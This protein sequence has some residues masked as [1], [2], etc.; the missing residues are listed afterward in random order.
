MSC[1]KERRK[2]IVAGILAGILARFLARILAKILAQILARSLGILHPDSLKSNFYCPGIFPFL[3]H[4]EFFLL[5]IYSIGGESNVNCS[6]ILILTR[7]VICCSRW[8]FRCWPN[9]FLSYTSHINRLLPKKIPPVMVH[10][11][12]DSEMKRTRFDFK[13]LDGV[14]KYSATVK[15]RRCLCT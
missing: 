6:L 5:R 10:Y 8:V 11:F 3:L 9:F 13:N 14:A 15:T 7:Q 1:S 12:V 4:Y 2:L